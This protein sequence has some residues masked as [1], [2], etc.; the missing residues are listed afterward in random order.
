MCSIME[1]YFRMSKNIVIIGGG[2]GGLSC[3]ALLARDGFKVTL[4]EK[5]DDVGGRARPWKTDGF[6]FDLGP[7]WYL[8]PEVFEHYFSL[9]KKE[10]EDYYKLT[11]L[12]PYYKVFFSDKESALLTADEEKNAALFETFEKGGADNFK[13]YIEQS[14]Y[15]YD[16]AMKEFL[17]KDYQ[18]MTQFFN[19]RIMSEGL[20]LGIFKKLDKFVSNYVQDRRAKQ[21]LE[22]AMVFLGTH[23][24]KAPAIYSIMSHV[25]LKLGVFFPEGG[26]AGAAQGFATLCKELNVNIVTGEEVTHIETKKGV[27]T[28]VHTNK[29]SYEADIVISSADYHHTETML[30]DEKDRMYSPSYW[31]KRVVAPSM[32]IV[33]LGINRELK[34]LEHHNLYFMEDWNKHFA[35][36]FDTPQWPNDPCFYLSCISKTDKTSAPKGAENV[37]LLVPT[38]PGLKDDD[39]TREKYL[40]HVLAHVKKVTGEDLT[41]DVLVKRVYSQRDFIEDYHSFKGTALGLSHTLMQTAIFR[42]TN[43]SKKVKNLYYTGQYTHPGVGVPMVLIASEILADKIQKVYG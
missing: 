9:F 31:E 26:M 1:Y 35:T 13:R 6:T 17:Y 29:S 33:Y 34:N 23:P 10:R 36:I 14:T 39:E 21:I 40:E 41:K 18:H 24:E 37:F 27:A 25:D 11:Q 30:L 42:P 38:A 2:F 20:R 8:M 5:L 16:V 22:Y 12:D 3:A 15:K 19:K 28:H 32:F 7:S 43:E 4:I